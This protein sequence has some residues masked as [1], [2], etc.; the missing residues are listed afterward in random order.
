MPPNKA[1]STKQKWGIRS[2][3]FYPLGTSSNNEDQEFVFTGREE[4][5]EEFC[6]YIERPRG[7]LLYGL[8]GVGKTLFL[9]RALVT[10]EQESI[11]CIYASFNPNHGFIK[12]L[13]LAFLK[14]L[15]LEQPEKLELY[16]KLL[17]KTNKISI[18]RT[19]EGGGKI[20]AF[21]VEINAKGGSKQTENIEEVIAD[22][23]QFLLD[24]IEELKNDGWQVVLALDDLDNQEIALNLDEE[25]T[26]E[27]S[28]TDINTIVREA[29]QLINV[30]ATVVLV[31]HPS[32]PTAALGS[33]NILQQIELA[34]L[35][36]SD[37][38]E[39]LKRYLAL[40]RADGKRE[41]KLDP[42]TEKAATLIANTITRLKLPTR[43]MLFA[44]SEL[45]EYCAKNGIEIIDEV[46]VRNQWP[47][48][49]KILRRSL[50][51]E[52]I[53]Y[54]KII[55]DKGGYDEDN[56]KAITEIAGDYGEFLEG[57]PKLKTLI[58]KEFL[59]ENIKGTFIR[60]PLLAAQN[61]F[62]DEDLAEPDD[63]DAGEL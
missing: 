10:L 21:G 36:I 50:K 31:G 17:G 39:M 33:S 54:L 38:I 24:R 3:P 6:S 57:L 20:G 61:P 62:T 25:D 11:F 7:L 29:R 35:D 23:L 16:Y 60:N 13:L 46:V 45:Y 26:P 59:I 37:L 1:H 41:L 5:L 19:V 49:V 52:D 53:N 27:I 42:F 12:T 4:D 40:G 22:H 30:G 34:S 43:Y 8:H 58:T 32:G 63:M 18:E 9:K 51:R 28:M 48:V 44:C 56:S 14:K 47:N 15:S 55:E 2:N